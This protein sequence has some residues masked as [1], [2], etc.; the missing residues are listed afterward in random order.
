MNFSQSSG[1]FNWVNSEIEIINSYPIVSRVVNEL[2][3][4]YSTWKK[5]QIP[6]NTKAKRVEQAVKKLLR[7]LNIRRVRNSNVIVVSYEDENPQLV[8]SI[9]NTVID[10]Y[11]Q[12]RLELSTKSTKND[13]L[14]QQCHIIEENLRQ[15]EER[16]AKFKK[17]RE[18][19]S[20]V[21]QRQILLTRLADY[22]K[23]LTTVKTNRISKE[24]KLAVIKKQLG[25]GQELSIPATDV[26]DSPSREKHIAKLKGDLLDMEIQREQLLQIFTPKYEEIVNLDKQ[27]TITYSKIK[28]EI[29][30]IINL[31]ETSIRALKAEENEFQKIVAEIKREVQEFAQKEYEYDQISRG[32]NDTKEVYSMLLKQREEARISLAKSERDIKIRIISP[33]IVPIEPIKPRKLLNFIMAIL[34][35]ILVGCGLAFLVNYFT[36][37][38]NIST[39]LERHI[40]L[41][42]SGNTKEIKRKQINRPRSSK[43][44]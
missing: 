14:D 42:N 11:I 1:D 43:K 39:E 12:Y 2:L 3:V 13:F 4:N 32:I 21:E 40:K 36:N 44:T 24:A 41:P 8:A 25:F 35:G 26:S 5:Q 7:K 29:L 9:V 15:L 38:I 34:L 23:N 30:Q 27:I 18:V 17:Q 28:D 19:I 33:A 16:L 22:E 37:T 6:E 10:N 20:P 31:E